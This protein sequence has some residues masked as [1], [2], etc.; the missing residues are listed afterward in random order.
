MTSNIVDNSA[1]KKKI[2]EELNNKQLK[3]IQI[4]RKLHNKD[5]RRIVKYINSSIF[6]ENKCCMWNGYVT[7]ETNSK[8][9]TY[10]NFFFRNKKVAL[11]RLLFENFVGILGEDYYLKFSCDDNFSDG[12]C[13]NINHMIKYKYNNCQKEEQKKIDNKNDDTND[14]ENNDA[15]D[16]KKN[17]KIDNKNNDTNDCEKK[18][19]VVK[20]KNIKS[21]NR[22]F[23]SGDLKI[24]F[25]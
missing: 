17:I 23:V 13:C 12:K 15:N 6:D 5:L 14:A 4:E 11:H 3:S 2:L 8:R 24:I 9:G 21:K 16:T 18:N 10:V 22:L 25:D 1:N 19:T 7:N 20:K